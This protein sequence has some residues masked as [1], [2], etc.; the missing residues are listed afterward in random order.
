M[1]I[2]A[3]S[4]TAVNLVVVLVAVLVYQCWMCDK[5]KSAV[6]GSVCLTMLAVARVNPVVV[7]LAVF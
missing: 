2:N 5:S 4:V 1:L 3:G 6:V 7:L